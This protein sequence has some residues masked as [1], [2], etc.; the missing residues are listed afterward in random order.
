MQVS[1]RQTLQ[2]AG[3]VGLYGALLA[4]GLAPRDALAFNPAAFQSK[5]VAETLK[6]L[7]VANPVESKGV[8]ITAPDIAENGAVVPIAIRSNLPKTQRMALLLEKNPNLLAG[9]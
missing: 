6:A 8:V 9:A 4:I 2:A 3:G 7:G 5:T 1:R